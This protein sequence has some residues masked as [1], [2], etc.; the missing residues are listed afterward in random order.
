MTKDAYSDEIGGEQPRVCGCLSAGDSNVNN[1]NKNKEVTTEP[2]DSVHFQ[3][4]CVLILYENLE[5]SELSA[6]HRRWETNIAHISFTR[7]VHSGCTIVRS[8]RPTYLKGK[9]S[10]KRISLKPETEN[11]TSQHSPHQPGL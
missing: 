9:E 2:E 11:V 3:V 5:Q 7:A 6:H 4:G 8:A 1:N 10:T